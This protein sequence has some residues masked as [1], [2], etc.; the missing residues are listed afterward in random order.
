[1]KTI[2]ISI[3]IFFAIMLASCGDPVTNTAFHINNKSQHKLKINFI[4]NEKEITA[5]INSNSTWTSSY[6]QL[7][8][9]P[10]SPPL[11]PSDSTI[12]TFDDSV[13]IT[14]YPWNWTGEN[15]ARSIMLEDNWLGGK[16]EDNYYRYEYTFTDADYQEA[17]EA[18]AKK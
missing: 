12:V 17:L 9:S 16:V 4:F 10:A 1:M 15:V 13:S 8:N 14:H 7:G 11:Y 6:S 5:E 3:S 2:I 18:N